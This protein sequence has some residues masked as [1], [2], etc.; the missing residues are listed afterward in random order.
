MRLPIAFAALV[1]VAACNFDTTT[2]N[3]PLT[4]NP[5]GT[6]SL[7]SIDGA[8]MPVS[9]VSNDTTTTLDTDVI[10]LDSIGDWSE[11][12]R[13]HRVVGSAAAVSDSVQIGGFWYGS[14]NSLNFRTSQVLLYIGTATDSTLTL[15]DNA[16]LYVFKR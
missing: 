5:A 6:Y 4:L 16:S 13:Y 11:L 9:T 7:Q 12:V 1:A 3:A 15:S 14:G 8:A 2:N 10:V